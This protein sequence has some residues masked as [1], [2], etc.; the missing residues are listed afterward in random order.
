MNNYLVI[1]SAH[2]DSEIKKIETI[3]TLKHLK[4][5]YIDVC[6]STHSNLYLDELSQYVK[7]TIYDENNGF[8]TLQGYVDNCRYIQDP[9]RYGI[10]ERKTFHDFGKVSTRAAVSPHSKSAL[11]LIKNGLILSGLNGYRWTIYLEY[12][13]KIPELG[14]KHFFDYHINRLVESGKKCF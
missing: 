10:S 11:L 5:S 13:V 4:E 2:V 3:K 8:L 1:F 7:Y 12:D 9:F 14:F 6:L